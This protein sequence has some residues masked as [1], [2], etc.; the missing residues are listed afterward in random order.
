MNWTRSTAG[1]VALGLLA[2]A[3]LSARADGRR[4]GRD[5]DPVPGKRKGPVE[6]QILHGH[7]LIS[8]VKLNGTPDGAHL[9]HDHENSGHRIFAQVR[10]R[11]IANILVRNQ[12]GVPVPVR[13]IVRRRNRSGKSLYGGG[14]VCFCFRDPRRG[15]VCLY[16]PMA[17]VAQGEASPPTPPAPPTPD[18]AGGDPPTPP[19]P[20]DAGGDAPAPP[21]NKT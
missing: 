5:G 13:K 7:N 15:W 8:Q 3:T 20:G 11:K 14:Y 19:D 18:D 6:H 10:N 1:A 16:F 17:A 9:I 4:K 12:R 21:A 2:V